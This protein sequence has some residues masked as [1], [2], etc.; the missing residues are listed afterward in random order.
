MSAQCEATAVQAA[1]A[2]AHERVR[3]CSGVFGRVRSC[4]LV[5]GRVRACSDRLDCA[6][7]FVAAQLVGAGLGLLIHV[8]MGRGTRVP[9]R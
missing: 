9:E 7:G 2:R 1:S 8:L 4:A 3:S 6:P 5:F